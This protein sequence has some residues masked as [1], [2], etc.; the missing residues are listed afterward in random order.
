MK[1]LVCGASVAAVVLCLSGGAF[2]DGVAE[3]WSCKLVEGKSI[4]DVQAVN[5]K[6]LAWVNSHVKGGGIKS[7]VGTPVVGDTESFI[8]VDSYPGLSAWAAAKEALSTEEGKA[9]EGQFNDVAKC[10]QNRLWRIE[11]TK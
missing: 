10:S 7:S 5:G 3:S 11:D 6:W 1:T 8:F 2:A 9:V 4:S